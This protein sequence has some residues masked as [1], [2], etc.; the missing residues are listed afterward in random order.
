[1]QFRILGLLEVLEDGRPLELGGPRQ[2]ALLA[3]L[4]LHANQVVA[5]ERLLEELWG[6][7]AAEAANALQV[8][9]SRLR[10][11]LDSPERLL[12]RSPGYLLRLSAGECDR[13]DF[14]KLVAQ[15]RQSQ[16]RE[17]RELAARTFRDALSLWRG[18]PLAD[19][20]YEPF[21]QAEIARL[22][23]A[24][25]ACLE[26]RV[27]ADL[28]L[29]RHA[30][31]V[32]DLE[33]LVREQPLRERL[34]S[35]LML[36]LYRSG[37]QAEALEAYQSA[38]HALIDELGIE[39]SQPLQHLERS[40]L[41]HDASLD[42][43]A[44]G[45]D[46]PRARGA[47]S[48]AELSAPDAVPEAG[49]IR[50]VRCKRESPPG[51]G[52]CLHC[53]E[54][55]GMACDGCGTV[56]PAAAKFC[57]GCGRAV[58]EAR[59]PAS[60]TPRHLR[61]LILARRGSIV[62][63]RKQVTVLFCDILR[64]RALA[65]ELGA[66][67]FH[68]AVDRFFGS[69]LE[70]VHRYEGTIS[71]FLGSG[72]MALF[73][74]PIA[75]Q[76]HTRRAVLAALEIVRRAELDV[77]IGINSGSV[78]VGAI[79][80]D[81]RLEY[82][83]FGDT[84]SM[85]AQLQASAKV[86]DVLVSEGTAE[87]VRGYFEFEEGPP[88]EA[89]ERTV[90]TL[91]V[92]GLGERTSRIDEMEELSPFCGRE[93]ELEALKKSLQAVFEGDGQVVGVVGDPGL[94]K[95]RLVFEFDRSAR[96]LATVLEGRCLSYGSGI[97]YLPL[98]DVV[99]GACGIAAGDSSDAVEAKLRM[100]LAAFKLDNE[101]G[102]YLLHALGVVGGVQLAA[103]DPPTIKGRTYEALR[104]LLLAE[105]G[106]RAL[107]LLVEDMH[108]IDRSSEEFLTEFVDELG[109]AP[110]LL[111]TTYRPGYKP[112]WIGK[113]FATQVAL[114]R[115]S[116]KASEQI[117]S[118]ILID[119]DESLAASIIVRGEGNPFFLEELARDARQQIDA[120]PSG[121]VPQ[122]VQ[123]VLAARIDR[124]DGVEKSAIQVAAV[125]GREFP[126]GLLEEIWDDTAPLLPALQELKRLEFLREQHSAGG[127]MFLFK[128]AL[129]REVAY[130]GLLE[131]R[132]R[133]L[134]ARVG[135]ALE[136]SHSDRLHEQYE[137]LAYHYARSAE[138]ERAAM[139]L[140]LANR[141]AAARHAMEEALGYFYDA[142]QILESLPD[143]AE[144]RRRRLALVFDQTGEFH[145]LH[146]HQEFYELLLRHEGLAVSLGEERLLGTFYARL[147]HRQLVFGDYETALQTSH[148]ALDLCLRTG[149]AS[150]AGLA[151]VVLT[152]T[153][154]MLGD[155]DSAAAF[156]EKCLEQ[157]AMEFHP[158][159][160]M[161]GYAGVALAYL[162]AG[163]WD[164][165][166]RKVDEAAAIGAERSD[167]GTVSFEASIGSL[168][169]LEKRDWTRA[170]EYAHEA[171]EIAP[172]LYF[173]GL[174]YGFLASGLCHTGAGEQG[175]PILE[176]IVPMI[177]ASRHELAWIIV[178]WRLADAYL[179]AGDLDQARDVL[180]D[181][182]ESARRSKAKFF[183]GASGRGLAE[184]ALAE[185]NVAQALR[186]LMPAIE[187]LRKSNSESELALALGALGRA[188]QLIGDEAGAEMHLR[189]AVQIL[190]RIG[191]RVEP[192]RLRKEPTHHLA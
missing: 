34:R 19:F 69:A 157:L 161:Y 172:T 154:A 174:A 135:A 111:L 90:R 167:S 89:N 136:R 105:A 67:E 55:I 123:D 53:G 23:E 75:H 169:C 112:P 99:R 94:G 39:P 180:A 72:L 176:Q 134:H 50:C 166:L 35:Q 140:E 129:T 138:R 26:G 66:E 186:H 133:E 152:W 80:D 120:A 121:V 93:V 148:T 113:S 153:H 143:S 31:L 44:V 42:L 81:L 128:H 59:A 78:V 108:W 150:D 184:I 97:P 165:A 159:W 191:T 79:G 38:R 192:E 28:A 60:Y 183:S 68:L 51:A 47:A 45:K 122:T 100:T 91:R 18:P 131:A 88:I 146:R 1:M 20:R 147:A 125:L 177:K 30:E 33:A 188:R 61:D 57:H 8:A 15:A 118:W 71:Q 11:A 16:S 142:L 70:E 74:A 12:T 185:G 41:R 144:N 107:I 127:G 189:E 37:R 54:Q 13:D 187:T 95:S 168:V 17:S 73:G 139:Y 40:I 162:M 124:L 63:E 145:W 109:S 64:A 25:L 5:A 83:A 43:K 49:A 101:H 102:D 126:L 46:P 36:A 170:L 173:R 58:E 141:K 119:A 9:V 76:D 115:L 181:V 160:H 27:E 130:D 164:D 22:E 175:L 6:G 87:S 4:L 85:A 132:R 106:R 171:N 116:P 137:L 14:E 48:A 52:F 117:V 32:G 2:R 92:T 84:T 3:R 77:R 96:Q 103:L 62:G 56:L 151:Y 178:A 10:R 179:V 182:H 98:L 155:Y 163:R 190:D 114:R 65:V 29:G 156:H 104:R 7:A 149:N 86:G 82:T 110:V 158:I 21:A 24:R